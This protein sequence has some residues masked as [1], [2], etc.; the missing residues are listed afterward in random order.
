VMSEFTYGR[1]ADARGSLA[2]LRARVFLKS[3][4]RSASQGASD[5]QIGK[6][7]YSQGFAAQRRF[8]TRAIGVIGHSWGAYFRSRFADG[9]R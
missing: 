3:S 4:Q 9:V 8:R 1:I 6:G 5:C 2:S 7:L